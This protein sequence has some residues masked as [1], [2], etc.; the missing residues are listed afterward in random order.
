L[1]LRRVE[2]RGC[3]HSHL[4]M[5]IEVYVSCHHHAKAVDGPVEWRSEW[6]VQEGIVE[7]IRGLSPTLAYLR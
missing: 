2:A 3:G 7:G 5:L 1:E 4:G 6:L